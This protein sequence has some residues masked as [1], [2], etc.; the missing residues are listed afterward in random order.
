MGSPDAQVFQ[1]NVFSGDEWE[2]DHALSERAELSGHPSAFPNESEMWISFAVVVEEGSNSD[3]LDA[4][5]GQLHQFAGKQDVSAEPPFVLH[6]QGRQLTVKARTS[7]ENP[8]VSGDPEPIIL[9]KEAKFPWGEWVNFVFHLKLDP[10]GDGL[11]EG[12]RNGKKIAGYQGPLG[13]ASTE[14]VYW[15]FGSYR[16]DL[17]GYYGTRFANVEV[18]Q[19][20]LS[21]RINDPIPIP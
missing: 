3:G 14:G 10:F 16:N 18:S 15:K 21:A 11:V 7:Q 17:S 8:L 13:F 2:G 1:F 6:L 4:Y 19:D 12:W 5:L 9:H 20:D